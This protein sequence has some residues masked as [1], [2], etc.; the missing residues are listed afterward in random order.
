MEQSTGN[1]FSVPLYYCAKHCSLA[2]NSVNATVHPDAGE[3]A[4]TSGMSSQGMRETMI[5]D[6]CCPKV[7]GVANTSCIHVFNLHNIGRPRM[8]DF[9]SSLDE[10]VVVYASQKVFEELPNASNA[11]SK[12][13]V[14]KDVGP[15]TAS[16]VLAAYDPDVAPFMSDESS[17]ALTLQQENRPKQTGMISSNATSL[18]LTVDR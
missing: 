14:L 10:G 18:D 11:I 17:I 6:G 9:V 4:G 16:A 8:L 12:L 3:G 15:A 13:T 7:N 2:N 1:C 5:T